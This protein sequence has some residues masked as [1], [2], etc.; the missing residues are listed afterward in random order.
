MTSFQEFETSPV[1]PLA[2]IVIDCL[3]KLK[4]PVDEK[5]VQVM[6]VNAH[7]NKA[8]D[9]LSKIQTE[10]IANSSHLNKS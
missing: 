8:N 2:L 9:A 4:V 6:L 3:L 7:D 5:L 10:I 1:N